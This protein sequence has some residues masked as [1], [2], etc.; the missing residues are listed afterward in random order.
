[1]P[2]R[3]K[4]GAKIR[5]ARQLLDMRQQ[6]LADKLNKSQKAISHWEVGDHDPGWLNILALAEIHRDRDDFRVVLFREP[7]NGDGRFKS[8]RI[9]EHDPHQAA[10][11]WEATALLRGAGYTTF[12]GGRPAQ[13]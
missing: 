6:D 12:D 1:M 8:A 4:I 9:R 10:L 2:D 7:R 13:A 11:L 3:P 5:R